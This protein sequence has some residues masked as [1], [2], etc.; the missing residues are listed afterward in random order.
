MKG[1]CPQ[2]PVDWI[3]SRNDGKIYFGCPGCNAWFKARDSHLG[4]PGESSFKCP[5]FC[6]L[7]KVHIYPMFLPERG[8]A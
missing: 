8:T 3:A 4:N 2:V 6:K 5:E 1:D 7:K